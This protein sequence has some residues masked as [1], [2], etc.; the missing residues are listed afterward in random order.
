MNNFHP[1]PLKGLQ[2]VQDMSISDRISMFYKAKPIIFERA[3]AMR[4]NMTPAE[5]AVWELLRS[6]KILSLRF[7]A[8]HP[9]DIFV[10]DFYCAEKKTIIELDGFVHNSMV[11]YDEFRDSELEYLGY[12]ILRIKNEELED[13]QDVL[14]KILDFINQ[15]PG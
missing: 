10:A 11:D 4:E 13:L 15:I 8:Q 2:T 14:S 5:K 7:K 3:K 9:I 1:K 12:R 6:N